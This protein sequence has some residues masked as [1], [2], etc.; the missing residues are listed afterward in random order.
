MVRFVPLQ[1]Q[2]KHIAALHED[3]IS[4]MVYGINKEMLLST[5]EIA[6]TSSTPKLTRSCDEIRLFQ[7]FSMVY[8][9]RYR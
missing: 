4:A 8:L 9:L 2:L 6:S 3:G 5:A 7:I 1:S